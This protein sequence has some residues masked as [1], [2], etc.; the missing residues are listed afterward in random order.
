MINKYHVVHLPKLL[1]K[2][3]L[4]YLYYIIILYNSELMIM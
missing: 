2:S 3:Q 1:L 4:I